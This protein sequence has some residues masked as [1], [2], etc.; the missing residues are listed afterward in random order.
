MEVD[1]LLASLQNRPSEVARRW[2]RKYLLSRGHP[3]TCWCPSE[4]VR[5]SSFT[6]GERMVT[7]R[8]SWQWHSPLRRS[9]LRVFGAWST[10]TRSQLTSI[11]RGQLRLCRSL[12]IEGRTVLILKDPGGEP[13]DQILEREKGQPLD[14]T[15]FLRIAIGL[16]SALGQVH[17]QGLIHK[18]IKPGNVLVDEAGNVWLIGFGI[19]SQLPREHQSPVASRD[20]CRHTRLYGARADRPHEP[21]HRRPQRSLLPGRHLVPDAYWC[22][23]RSPPPTRWSGSTATSRAS[24]YRLLDAPQSRSHCPLSP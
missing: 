2:R 6:A 8:R 18:D 20:H 23:C 11:P 17:R 15:R 21:L 7:L 13:L 9:H 24:R 19:A 16:A 1:V 4:S 5:T 22:R 10:N 14:L 3:G 12:V